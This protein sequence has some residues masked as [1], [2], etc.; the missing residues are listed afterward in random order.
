MNPL[1][2]LGLRLAGGGGARERA[3]AGSV[4]LACTIG[5]WVLLNALAIAR[6]EVVQIATSPESERLLVA[7]LAVVTMPVLVLIATATRLSATLRDRRLAG[8]RLLGLSPR[9]TRLV[10]AVES[11]VVA[12]AGTLL[13]V[14]AFWFS[15]P[16]LSQLK[17]AGRDWSQTSFTPWL[18][19]AVAVVV[20][21]PLV[22][23]AVSL[24]PTR[25]LGRD[26][27]AQSRV[28]SGRRP[29]P[30]RLAPL[31]VGGPACLVTA[32]TAGPEIT[33]SRAYVFFA[34]GA[35][36]ALGLLLVVPVFVRLVADLMVLV[37]ARPALRIAGRRLQSQPAAVSR[38]VSGLL[39]GLFVVSGART[40]VGAFEDTPQY[41]AAENALVD[42]PATYS[43]G[44]P[45]GLEQGPAFESIE[46]VDGVRGVLVDRQVMSGCR[47]GRGCESA[48]VGTCA[49][50][51]LLVPG[52]SGCRD[53][54]LSWL[55]EAPR[56]GP[57]E[58]AWRSTRSPG[59]D[60]VE[61]PAPARAA[62]IGLAGDQYA[63][64]NALSAG[65]FIPMGTPGIAALAEHG[66]PGMIAVTDPGSQVEAS[67]FEAVARWGP[68]AWVSPLFSL[69]DYA[70]VAGL[71]A[72]A[73]AV[74]AVVLSVGLLAFAVSAVDRAI[75]R[76]AEMVSLQLLGT[77]RSVIRAAQL[78]EA[79]LPLA[80]GLPG[81]VLLGWSVGSG[82]L[83]LGGALRANPWQSTLALG[84]I[85]TMA[86]VL[87][88]GL[89][90]VA[91]APRVRADLI[92]RA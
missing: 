51:A 81:A 56:R 20:G 48:F 55:D 37:P 50:L 24:I 80:L 12:V 91:S 85:A 41:V 88:A 83:A 36:C 1:V 89:T 42:G 72:M 15:R 71:R 73:W 66:G 58:F 27:L 9:A 67:L 35:L 87:I 13:G 69:D 16:L 31:V 5:T 21:V 32:S 57:A 45:A 79:L 23:V 19:A 7:V 25:R 30:W 44:L 38:I 40:V 43:V 46:A 68:A 22:A 47:R 75:S 76:R 64:G 39:I 8:L 26:V 63:V 18:G 28:A 60:P 33:D 86:A 29:S 2:R 11:G 3:R 62:V 34:G 52:V 6:T 10:A 84:A 77:P 90:V 92:R 61:L 53:D 65:V 49:D 17:V 70:F 74:A 82:Y 78:W 54:Q 4:V 59:P 14:A